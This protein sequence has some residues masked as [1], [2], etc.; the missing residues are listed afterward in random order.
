MDTEHRESLSQGLSQ[1]L[2]DGLRECF[3]AIL[4]E[5]GRGEEEGNGKITV[6]DLGEVLQAMGQK[7]SDDDLFFLLCEVDDGAMS[8]ELSFAEFLQII[9]TQKERAVHGDASAHDMLDAYVACGGNPD[10]GGNVDASTLI[11][12]V[13]NDFGL[14]INIE[15]LIHAVD[16]DG[17]GEIE[18]EE[19]ESLLS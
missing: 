5:K 13:K 2:I 8:G 9:A 14:T 10:G 17:S 1:E 3:L 4:R 16:A 11:R 7:P 6:A 19:F 15:E 12:I 18:F